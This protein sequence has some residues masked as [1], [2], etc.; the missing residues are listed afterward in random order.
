MR[1]DPASSE[2][3]GA[4]ATADSAASAGV[5]LT[6]RYRDVRAQTLRLRG[7]LSE[8]DCVVQSMPDASP[9]KWHLAHT[10]WFFET[11]VLSAADADYR[12]FDPAYAVLF[13]SYYNSVGEQYSRPDRGLLTRPSLSEVTAYRFHVDTCMEKLLGAGVSTD[14]E[15]IIEL[16]LHHEQQHQELMLTDLKHLLSRNPLRPAMHSSRAWRSPANTA[17]SGPTSL[18]VSP[19]SRRRT[20]H[21]EKAARR[22]QRHARPSNWAAKTAV[23]TPKR[24]GSSC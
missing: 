4:L 10:S 7:S 3:P 21:W 18:L 11:F 8:E 22:W 5:S 12:C 1:L 13:N 24:K 19:C 16:G 15:A 20:W 6:D 17:C 14:M 2:H 23:S 9:L